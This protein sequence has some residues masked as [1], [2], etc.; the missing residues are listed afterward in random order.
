MSSLTVLQSVL[1][2]VFVAIHGAVSVQDIQ[3]SEAFGG[4]HGIAFSDINSIILGQTISIVTIR[5]GDR[6]DAVT[7]QVAT[8]TEL[9]LSHG[10]SSGT[11]NTLTLNSDE[12]ITSM[13]IHWGK[14]SSSTLVSYLNFVT[15]AGNSISGG[16]QTEDN[17]TVTA[18]DGFQLSG[19]FGRAEGAVDQ[20]GAIWT[21]NEATP[22]ELMDDM[23]SDWYGITIRNWV[24]PT[25]SDASDTACY[26]ETEAFGSGK[27]CPAGY[28]KSG[29]NCITECPISYPTFGV[30]IEQLIETATTDLGVSVAENEYM[31]EVAN[32]G[33]TVLSGLDP[34]GI[35]GMMAQFVQPTCGP[36]A[37]IGEIDDGTLYDA[38]GLTT[39][40]EAFAGSYGR[41]TKEGDGIVNLIFE[42]T[43]TKGVKVVI[44]SGGDTI[45][46]VE[47]TAGETV[48]W[49]STVL[50]LQDKTM[51]LDRWRPNLVGIPGSGGGSLVLWVPRSSS[52]GHLT[53]HVRIN[54]S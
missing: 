53:M 23:G 15:S 17:S 4:S 42:S 26:R 21:R 50:A 36:T 34:T 22:T 7:L 37:F 2:L 13:E 45:E 52:G 35:A 24:G 48:T 11:D 40:D 30:I 31:L 51:Y 29:S 39:V 49:N 28:S 10:G 16:T 32:M 3:L 1:L 41:W 54:A 9:T 12:F 47:V 5:A 43:D 27:V 18:P 6:I 38:L 33:L 14:K 44:H 8:P 46:K 19:L 25:I 20:L